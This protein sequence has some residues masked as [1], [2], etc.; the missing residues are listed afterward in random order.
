MTTQTSTQQANNYFDLHTHGLGY[1][2]RIRDVDPKKGNSFIAC[3]IAALAG[4]SDK[5]EYRYFDVNVVGHEAERLIK[6][7]E[8]AV[9]AKKK[10]LISFV[11]ADLWTDI[12]TYSTDSKFHKKGDTGVSLKG[13]LIRIK[14]IKIDGELKYQEQPKQNKQETLDAE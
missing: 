6:K 9:N 8:N 14:M 5:P 10:V 1:L 4:S 7:C 2:S 3:Q 12:F 13:R 11:I